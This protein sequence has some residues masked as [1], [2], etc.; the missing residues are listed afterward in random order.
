MVLLFAAFLS[1][2]RFGTA[3]ALLFIAAMIATGAGF[4]IFLHET[5]LGTRAVR[6]GRISSSMRRTR[7]ENPTGCAH[8][9]STPIGTPGHFIAESQ[10]LMVSASHV[11]ASHVL[12]RVLVLEM[13]RVTEAAAIAASTLDRPR[14]Q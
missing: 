8:R 1:G 12:D 5:R 7:T 2:I 14:R 3:I 4:A 11:R 9:H 10:F 13:V 6:V